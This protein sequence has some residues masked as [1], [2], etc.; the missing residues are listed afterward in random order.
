M[1]LYPVFLNL[2]GRPCVVIGGGQVAEQKVAG[3]LDAGA[4]VTVI[5]RTV[6]PGLAALA[7]QHRI[8]LRPRAYRR[9]DLEGMYLAIAAPD[10]RTVNR[11]IWEEAE[12]RRVLLNAVDDLPHCTFIAPA[13]HRQGDL[14]VAIGTAGK[15]PALAVRL[16]DRFAAQIGPEYAALLDLLG[17]LRPEVTRRVPDL[18]ARTTLW[19]RMVDSDALELVRRG[20]LTGA[21]DLLMQLLDGGGGHL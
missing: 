5:S 11:K 19:Y 15:S 4:A 12:H 17:E 20:N 9:G 21:K 7:A 18:P 8:V 1:T 13:I 10:D 2:Q 3:L 16:R 6:S 14:T